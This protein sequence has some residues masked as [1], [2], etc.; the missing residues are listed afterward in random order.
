MKK[1][2]IVIGATG[3]VGNEL[4]KLL[5]ADDQYQKIRVFSRRT[6]GFENEKLNEHLVDFDKIEKWKKEVKGDVLFSSLGTTIKQAGSKDAQYKVDYTYQFQVAKAAAENGVK[7]LVLISSLGANPKSSIFYS[8][9]KGELDQAVRE[10]PFKSVF[11][12]RPSALVGNRS[13]ER[14]GEKMMIKTTKF[15]SKIFPFLKK[16]KPIDATIVAKAMVNVVDQYDEKKYSI[17]NNIE[18]FEIARSE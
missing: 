13:K 15:F 5:L 4:V 8:R 14:A 3:L 7:Q 17:F 12:F 6:T 2:A 16:Y 1:T 9:I 10:L 18:L 11:I